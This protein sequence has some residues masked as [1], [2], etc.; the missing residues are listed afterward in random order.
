MAKIASRVGFGSANVVVGK[1]M[2]DHI[3]LNVATHPKF[4]CC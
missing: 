3:S 1:R 4:V 2:A